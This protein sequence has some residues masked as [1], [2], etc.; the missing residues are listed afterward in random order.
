MFLSGLEVTYYTTVDWSGPINQTLTVE[1]ITSASYPPELWQAWPQVFSSVYTGTFMPNTTGL[2]HFSLTGQGDALLTIDNTLIANMTGANF[3]NTIQGIINLTSGVEV[4]LEMKYS[5]G[6][7]LSTGGYGITL[8]VSVGNTTRDTDA[9]SLAAEADLSII[10]VSDRHSEGVDNNLALSLPGDQDA[11]I[12]RLSK[13]SKKTLV[14]LNTNSAILMPWID[15]VDAVMEAWYSG[16]QVGLALGNL[17]YGKINPSGKLPMTFPKTLNDTIQI[18]EELEVDFN[19]G[20]YVGYKWFDEHSIAPLF[21]FG[22]GLSYTTFNLFSL[23]LSTVS[24]EGA[25][26][27]V[28]SSTLA[29]TGGVGGKEVVQVYVSYPAAAME[30]PKLLKGFEKVSLGNGE[31]TDVAI[32]IAKEDLRIWDVAIGDW[33]LVEGNY[34]F[35]VGFSAGDIVLE[36][37]MYISS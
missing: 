11:V 4:S 23:E 3:G 26:S 7:S 6:A 30:P 27:V 1:N 16:Q 37:S 25:E 8:G 24:V 32:V 9:D 36:E 19:E 31:E 17:L 13:L 14:V 21:P 22:H 29:N 35:M 33:S 20:L 2:Y 12:A 18:W 10:F 5:M 28:V 15:S 34:T